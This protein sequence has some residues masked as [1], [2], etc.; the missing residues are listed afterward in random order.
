MTNSFF[1]V[2]AMLC[3]CLLQACKNEAPSPST[4]LLYQTNRINLQDCVKDST[5]A[6]LKVMYVQFTGGTN[7]VAIS[8]INDSIR[9]AALDCVGADPKIPVP[10]TFDSAVA[11]LKALMMS[12]NPDRSGMGYYREF[13]SKLRLQNA[14]LVSV[15][16]NMSDYMG[17]AHGGAA[18]VFS[19]YDLNTGKSIPLTAV[20]SDTNALRPMLDKGFVGAKKEGAEDPNLQL[21]DLLYPGL[22]TLP[23]STNFCILNEGLAFM[24]Q[25]YEVAPWAVGATEI[26]LTWEQL[27]ALVDK[28]KWLK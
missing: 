13:D 3:F 24:Y 20:V 6:E 4:P 27:G 21:T 17:G 22:T 18:S 10:A 28:R 19:S 7:P 1:T 26:I 9:L 2:L 5:C 14:V 12:D 16:M 15:E 23:I 11:T 8:A 25:P